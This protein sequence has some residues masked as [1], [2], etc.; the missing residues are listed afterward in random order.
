M[1]IADR[2]YMRESPTK[3]AKPKTPPIKR[4]ENKPNWRARVRFWW[5]RL[6]KHR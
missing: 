6:L 3:V 4:A 1:G 2:D 5:W